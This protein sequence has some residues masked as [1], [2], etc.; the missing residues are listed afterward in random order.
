M[1]LPRPALVICCKD[2]RYIQPIQRFIR[3]RGVRWYDLKATA[4]GL[5]ALLDAPALVRRWIL[6]DVRLVWRL[7]GVRRMLIVQHQD[8]AG[9]GGS[10]VFRDAAAERRFHRRQFQRAQRL[11]TRTLRGVRVEGFFASGAPGRVH[12]EAF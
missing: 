7:H 4:G 11:L 6:A 9:Y 5:R 10:K 1:T 2:Y 3:R 8:C 12:V